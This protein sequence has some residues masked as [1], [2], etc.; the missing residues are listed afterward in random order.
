M[1]RRKALSLTLFVFLILPLVLFCRAQK[2]FAQSAAANAALS[3]TVKSSDGKPLEGVG[4]SA[5]NADE[6]FTTTV[7]T[8]QAGRYFFPPLSARPIQSLGAGRGI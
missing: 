2:I 7:Y 4:V 3:G 8:D 1:P 6:T 5:R